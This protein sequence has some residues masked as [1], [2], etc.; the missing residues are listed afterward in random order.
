MTFNETILIFFCRKQRY[1]K[2]RIGHDYVI[3][4]DIDYSTAHFMK[5]FREGKFGKIMFDDIANI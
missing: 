5:L 2:R 4:T 3:K 1:T